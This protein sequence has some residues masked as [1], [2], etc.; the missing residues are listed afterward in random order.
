M[1]DT[2]ES[3][4][5]FTPPVANAAEN[6]KKAV[7]LEK[8]DGIFALLIFAA[9]F[10]FI[11]FAVMH[12]FNLGFS[13][14]YYV[15]FAVFTAYLAKRDVRP[16]VFSCLCGII[17]LAGAATFTLSRNI[18]VNFIMLFLVTALFTIYAF[19]VSGTF[20][21]NEGSAKMLGEILYGATLSP[22]AN[23]SQIA[24]G[25]NGV[26]VKSKNAVYIAAGIVISVP[27]LLIIIPLLVS[28]DAAFRGLMQMIGKNIGEYI[29][30]LILT[31]IFAPF[32]VAYAVVRR[33]NLDSG[34]SEAA[35]S[36]KHRFLPAAA[37][38]SFLC[39]ISVTYL[40]YLFS[41]LAYF[42]SA[43]SGFLP[44]GYEHTASVYARQGFFEMFAI[45][46]INLIIITAVNLFCKREKGRGLPAFLRGVECFILL[47]TVII[48]ITAMSKMKLNI[49]IYGLSIYRLLVAI[50]MV[51][52]AVILAFFILHIIAPKISYM[53]PVI[54]ICSIIFVA[55]ALAD[56]DGLVVRYNTAAYESGTLEELDLDYFAQDLSESAV[57]YVIGLAQED[58]EFADRAI[59][60]IAYKLC[61]DP[62]ISLDFEGDA[63]KGKSNR[64]F[65][66]FNLTEYIAENS[67]RDYYNSLSQEMKSKI[68]N[69]IAE[70]NNDAAYG[71]EIGIEILIDSDNVHS[72]EFDYSI[73]GKTVCS[74]GCSPADE[75]LSFEY[76]ETV[77]CQVPMDSFVYPEIPENGVFGITA[78][79]FTK[80]GESVPIE[81][82]Y[83]WNAKFGESYRFTLHEYEENK[84][85]LAPEFELSGD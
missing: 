37:V 14:S 59:D 74:G 57:P 51:M 26:A 32:A 60:F 24:R 58:K 36:E 8:K 76:G 70:N 63:L 15:F 28:G 23:A 45:C 77:Y 7:F 27:A 55:F 35:V 6:T 54:L 85:E 10:I 39:V 61:S 16:S 78:T 11:D 13:I 46:V 65:R 5:Y 81:T 47:F 66:Q 34:K 38:A 30:V 82:L 22:L 68:Y 84:F 18:L 50:F 25:V 41:Q 17:S 83:E 29:A 20:R 9:V 31:V 3:G 1:N 53:Q 4:A 19:G 42:F 52:L 62:D 79:V 69:R 80:D 48:L 2:N 72:L 44:E 43:F 67:L 56:T 73:D 75:S 40:V 71:Y 64:D 21:Q 12:G 33:K 49:E